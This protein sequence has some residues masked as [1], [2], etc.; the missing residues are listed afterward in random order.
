MQVS[1][2]CLDAK[3]DR[4]MCFSDPGRVCAIEGSQARVRT[5]DGEHEVSLRLM[6][7]SGEHVVVGDWV[8]VSLGLVVSVVDDAAAAETLF[9]EMTELRR[10]R[11]R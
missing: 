3:G 8:L 9:D 6:E 2:V 10:G 7:A 1:V 4:T 11:G 5:G